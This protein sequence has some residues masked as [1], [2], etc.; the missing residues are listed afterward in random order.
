MRLPPVLSRASVLIGL[1]HVISHT[2]ADWLLQLKNAVDATAQQFAATVTLTA[3][4][5][6]IA[7]TA[8]ET[9]TLTEGYYELAWYARISRAATTSSSLVVNAISTDA[10]VTATQSSAAMTGNTTGTAASGTFIVKVDNTTTI[11]YSTT[12]G[13]VGGTSM[14]YFLHVRARRLP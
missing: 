5:A 2:W 7:A 4:G 10:A 9:G 3:Q 6:S 14:Q 13:S 8:M 12:Y 11:R 1:P